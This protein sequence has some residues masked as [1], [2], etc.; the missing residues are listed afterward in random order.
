MAGKVEVFSGKSYYG[1]KLVL[2]GKD[3]FG[4]KSEFL[5]EISES[6]DQTVKAMIKFEK[7]RVVALPFYHGNR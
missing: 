7:I 6:E 3:G 1:D 5:Q 2:A 4:G